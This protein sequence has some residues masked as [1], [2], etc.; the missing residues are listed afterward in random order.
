MNIFLNRSL[1]IFIS[2]RKSLWAAKHPLISVGE[3]GYWCPQKK[4]QNQEKSIYKSIYNIQNQS[5]NQKNQYKRKL[6]M[7]SFRFSDD[8]WIFLKSPEGSRIKLKSWI[9]GLISSKIHY[10]EVLFLAS[11]IILA[12]SWHRGMYVVNY[13]VKLSCE[14]L[15]SR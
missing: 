9:S 4:S 5:I 10:F 14:G 7:N 3:G 11:K 1:N 2:N 13:E 8:N 12:Q 15:F 6:E